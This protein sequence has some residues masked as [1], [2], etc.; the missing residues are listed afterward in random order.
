MPSTFSTNK[1][2]E[3]QA[4][5]EHVNT[6]G[7]VLNQNFQKIDAN[8]AGSF[9]VTITSA[10]VT[11][12]EAQA[13]NLSY[14]VTGTMTG[15]RALVFPQNGGFFIINNGTSGAY[16][17]TVRM[18]TGASVIVPQG[19]ITFVYSN[20][21][22]M[23]AAAST[24]STVIDGSGAPTAPAPDG[25]VYY[26]ITAIQFY[27]RVSGAW[28]A[29]TPSY[30][31]KTANTV[32]AG[33]ASGG[34]A[35]PAYRALVSDDI[36]LA[37]T[38]AKGGVLLGSATPQALGTA[39]TG[40]STA[41]AREDHV[42]SNNNVALVGTPTAPTAA[43]DTN[44]TQIATTAYVIGQ[45]ASA[46]PSNLGPAAVGTSLRFARQDHVHSNVNVSLTGVP[47]APTAPP[48]T[49]TTQI[50]TTAYVIGQTPSSGNPLPFLSGG[51]N[52]SY[53]DA[54]ALLTGIGAVKKAGDTSL[55]PM[56]FSGA[57][58]ETITGLGT[59]QVQVVG[60]NYATSSIL[61]AKYGTNA[62]RPQL[63]TYRSAGA[64]PGSFGAVTSGTYGGWE[65]WVD[66]GAGPVRGS[67]MYNTVSGTAT[68]TY[69]PSHISFFNSNNAGSYG[70]R[71][72][73]EA[74]GGLQ[75]GATLSAFITSARH[76]IFRTY[77]VATLP[78]PS[79]ANIGWAQ[80]SNPAAGKSTLVYCT[81]SAWQYVDASAV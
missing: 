65:A 59:M 56:V 75:C 23:F 10:D 77:T 14:A 78:T 50:A 19:E 28:V 1:D 70:E 80:V 40:T 12:T 55:G 60:T 68:T 5:G 33:P 42:H 57:T 71:F 37:T 17:L 63:T 49:N 46:T 47:T 25:T 53:A 2:Y 62:Q 64:A 11:L 13:S 8:L 29:A 26:D 30:S 9:P 20:G 4:T 18:A 38:S 48:G 35:T 24:A 41:M 32:L 45:A 61:L 69:V 51:T 44:T 39:A 36:P 22:G 72:R 76:V 27:V 79:A 16:S 3:L 73:V 66:G 81:G 54:N 21:A 34:S 43:V 7:I 58:A 31:P 6:W 74:D 67:G 15:D 52:A